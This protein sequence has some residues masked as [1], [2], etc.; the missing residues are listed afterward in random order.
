MRVMIIGAGIGGLALAQGLHRAGIDVTVYERDQHRTDR[1]QGYRI[2]LAPY[3][4]RALHACLP[5][6][7]YDLFVTTATAPNTTLSFFTERLDELLTLDTTQIG[8]DE[9]HPVDSYKSVSRITL[10]QVLLAGL[11]EQVRYGKTCTGYTRTGEQVTAHFSDGSQAVAD[12]LVGA[13]GTHSAVRAQLLPHAG[14]IDTGAVALAGKVAL[15]EATMDLLPPQFLTGGAMVLAP[16]GYSGFLAA[17]RFPPQPGAGLLSD[18][19]SDYI[20]WNVIANRDRLAGLIGGDPAAADIRQLALQ[21]TQGWHPHL[22]QLIIDGDP[23]TLAYLPLRTSR[24]PQPW[25]PGNVTVLGDAVHAMPPTAGAGANTALVDADLLRAQL[26]AV[27]DGRLPL[28]AAVGAYERAMLDHA[29]A[30]VAA[31]DRN[32]ANA[33]SGSRLALAGF[34]TMLRLTRRVGPIRRRMTAAIAA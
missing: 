2:H 15:T 28:T 32:L 9:N 11:A 21:A 23:D 25:Q 20:M 24:R 17:H 1:L 29:F 13:D 34:R 5:P 30:K 22:R 33:V 6:P 7:V 10:R 16:G 27:R 18:D 12:V 14:R 19:T 4:C 31:A 8:L 26:I 3:G